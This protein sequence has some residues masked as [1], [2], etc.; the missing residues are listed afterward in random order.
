MNMRSVC[1][2]DELQ[3]A[4]GLLLATGGPQASFQKLSC[5]SYLPS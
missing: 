5:A 2:L 3:I 4:R 1:V